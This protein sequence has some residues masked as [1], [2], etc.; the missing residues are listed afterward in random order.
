MRYLLP[1]VRMSSLL[2]NTRVF[3]RDGQ[4]G[5]ILREVIASI[6]PKTQVYVIGGAARN[7]MYFAMFKKALPQRDFDL[8]LIGDLDG[9]VKNVRTHKFIYG[10]IRRKNDIVLKKKL[11][12]KPEG[13]ADLLVLDIHRSYEPDVLKNLEQNAAFSINGFA[14][15][16][17]DYLA[18]DVTKHCI[19]LPNAKKDLRN[20]VLR[21][22]VEGSAH[23]AGN[24]FACLRF[25]SIGFAPP[26]KQSVALLLSQLPKLEKWRFERNVQKVFGYVGG[27]VAARKLAKSLGITVDIFNFA[28]L[29]EYAA[30]Q[31]KSLE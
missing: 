26:D 27:E 15:P 30:R 23:H 25:M 11:V 29:K 4:V 21:L 9:F 2:P 7:A 24:L 31:K 16:L 3:S 13:P 17:A 28:A 1:C 12:K 22:N 10:K 20:H 19:A 6:P 14:I 5:E 18:K 8:L